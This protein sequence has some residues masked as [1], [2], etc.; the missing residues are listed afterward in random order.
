MFCKTVNKPCN[1]AKTPDAFD[2]LFNSAYLISKFPC[3]KIT[4]TMIL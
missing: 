2:E 4:E 3:T 1:D